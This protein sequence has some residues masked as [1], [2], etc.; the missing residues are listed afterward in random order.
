MQIISS[1]IVHIPRIT[2][3][4]RIP[5][6]QLQGICIGFLIIAHVLDLAVEIAIKKTYIGIMIFCLGFLFSW[7][8]FCYG[9]L[10]MTWVVAVCEVRTLFFG[11]IALRA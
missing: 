8:V 3:V 1:N 10:G 2:V 4:V 9:Y 5:Q 11:F 6:L 7:L